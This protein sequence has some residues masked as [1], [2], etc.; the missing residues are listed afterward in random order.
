MLQIRGLSPLEEDILSP[1]EIKTYNFGNNESV[2]YEEVDKTI[3]Q[4]NNKL[5][6]KKDNPEYVMDRI[7]K[8]IIKIPSLPTSYTD[9]NEII[10]EFI[11]GLF[12]SKYFI[13]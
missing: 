3:R 2:H 10:N 9:T 13:G 1:S 6:I 12:N 7:S 4:T 8:E 11:K 5:V